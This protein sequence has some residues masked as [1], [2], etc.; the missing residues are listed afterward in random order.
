MSTSATFSSYCHIT[1]HSKLWLQTGGIQ[2]CSES[3]ELSW[4][5]IC[6]YG[7]Q[8]VGAIGWG[9]RVMGATCPSPPSS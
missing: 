1:K 7:Q 6:V 5:Y 3:A 8:L 2:C 9:S 4:A